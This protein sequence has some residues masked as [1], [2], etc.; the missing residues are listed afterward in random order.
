MCPLKFVNYVTA[1]YPVT[2]SPS[3]ERIEVR[4]LTLTLSQRA[5]EHESGSK[6]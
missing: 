6:D 3:G 5:R 4:A 2:F 1:L